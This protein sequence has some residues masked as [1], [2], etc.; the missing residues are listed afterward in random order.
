MTDPLS[1]IAI[2]IIAGF[3]HGISGLG[4]PLV[5][6]AALVSVYPLPHVIILVLF[7]TMAMNLISWLAGGGKSLKQN[8]I[9]YLRHYWLLALT[10][11][12]GS[13]F[14]A[15][16]LTWLNP[17]YLMLMLAMVIWFYVGTALLGRRIHLPQ[18]RPVLIAVGLIA[19]M[20]GGAT[21]AMSPI[22]LMYLLSASDDKNTIA[23][24]GNLCYL[25]GKVAQII[26]LHRP[27]LALSTHDW[28]FI[29]SLTAVSIVALIGG[30]RL[31]R[32]LPQARFRQLILAI[33]TLLGG[34]VGWQGIQS[35]L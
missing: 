2:F 4:F 13:L 8:A 10:A 3:L 16:L 28:A 35:F 19:G 12:A 7:P 24:V 29:F 34:K 20:V 15:R 31:R 6:T 11:L 22:L 33:L 21:N 18:T 5:T 14:G 1:L 23:K 25:I 30:I 26:V 17:A 27:I 32:H 9:Y